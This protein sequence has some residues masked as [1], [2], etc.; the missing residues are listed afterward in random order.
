MKHF[1]IVISYE[2]YNFMN[3]KKLSMI[4]A[5]LLFTTN[6]EHYGLDE[7]TK[8]T[9]TSEDDDDDDECSIINKFNK[10]KKKQKN[11]ILNEKIFEYIINKWQTKSTSF[12]LT[13]NRNDI[14][15]NI[16]FNYSFIFAFRMI[17]T[18]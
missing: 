9:P 3:A 11:R 15:G 4:F 14:T 12:R 2:K 1:K 10:I 16:F 7:N 6:N 17:Y 13:N 5:N 18:I 8:T